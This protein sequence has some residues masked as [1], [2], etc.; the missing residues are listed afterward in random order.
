M[1]SCEYEKTELMAVVGLPDERGRSAE[2][3]GEALDLAADGMIAGVRLYAWW[4]QGVQYVGTTGRTLKEA[5]TDI[6][7]ANRQLCAA[8]R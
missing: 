3:I 4:E 2:E 1:M 5:I 7:E 8:L 6:N